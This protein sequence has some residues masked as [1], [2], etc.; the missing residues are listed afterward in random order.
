MSISILALHF[1]I[2]LAKIQV[3][4]K[5]WFLWSSER[6]RIPAFSRTLKCY[7]G[8]SS[9]MTTGKSNN[10]HL[11]LYCGAR[12]FVHRC[13]S[14]FTVFL[15]FFFFQEN[16][17]D[18]Q[19]GAPTCSQ[20]QTWNFSWVTLPSTPS[21]RRHTDQALIAFAIR[22]PQNFAVPQNKV[23]LRLLFSLAL[24]PPGVQ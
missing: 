20:C 13:D 5:L 19:T 24:A 15:S 2:C 6:G 21:L 7:F 10:R 23:F 8:I 12:S 18:R 1:W 11:S 17:G 22:K 3:R 16:A 9:G 4:I 14:S